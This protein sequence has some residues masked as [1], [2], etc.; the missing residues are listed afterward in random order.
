MQ[1]TFTSG[2]SSRKGGVF[3]NEPEPEVE[4]TT[5]EKYI[6]KEKERK[7]RRKEKLKNSKNQD[8]DALAPVDEKE[9]GVTSTD[10]GFDDPFFTDPAATS[11]SLKKSKKRAQRDYSPDPEAE[12]ERAHLEALTAEDAAADGDNV[13][14][15]D[16]ALLSKGEKLSKKKR[17]H[18]LSER[19]KAAL[20]AKEKDNFEINAKD[21]RFAAVFERSEYAI[22][23][24]HK[25][26]KGTEGM[27]K[28]LEE[29]RKKRGWMARGWKGLQSMGQRRR[30][31]GDAM[32]WRAWMSW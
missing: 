19:Q 11:A 29:G 31:R 32:I 6:R 3:E 17:K 22:D 8:A 20:E 18:K 13:Q 16:S 26:Y 21:P 1:I 2:L 23:P 5:V 30:R 28:L 10:A 15:F 12:A 24:S 27:K 14:H 9:N 25:G 7:N 4:E